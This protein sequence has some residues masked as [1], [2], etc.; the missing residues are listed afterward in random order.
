MT[1]HE[2]YEIS[3]DRCR[4]V[5]PW[6]CSNHDDIQ[7]MAVRAGWYRD[8][9]TDLCPRC[10]AAIEVPR[11]PIEILV[12]HPDGTKHWEEHAE[13]G[14]E[15]RADMVKKGDVVRLRN[16]F[17]IAQDVSLHGE[18][19]NIDVGVTVF[20]SFSPGRPIEV[21]SARSVPRCKKQGSEGGSR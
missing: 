18:D 7:R 11:A 14:V 20:G 16:D 15:T 10:A 19:V 8:A 2:Y 17:Y 13:S 9:W 21:W 12:T 6:R 4:S 5:G 1:T 3:C